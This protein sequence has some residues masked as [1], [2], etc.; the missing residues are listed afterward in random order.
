[1]YDDL[2]KAV[3]DGQITIVVMIDLS[4]AF[5]T[6]DIPIAL[7]ILHDD[8]GIDDVPL[9]WIKSYLTDR[10]MKVIINNDSSRQENL[11]FG[12]PQGSCA[13]L[14]IFTLYIAALKRVVKKYPAQLHGY[15]D[16]HKVALQIQAGN[17]ENETYVLEQL[18][19]CLDNISS[20]MAKYKLKM[21]NAKTEIILYEIPVYQIDRLQRLQNQAARVVMNVYDQPSA[22]LRKSL[23]WLPVK[24]RIMFKVILIV[25]RVIHGTA[26]TYLITLFN[27]VRRKYRLRSAADDTCTQFV[28]PRRRTR[29]A[30][31][32]ISV[33]GPKWWNALPKELKCIASIGNC[34]QKNTEST[35]L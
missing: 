14:V 34:I 32:S 15:A 20:W 19:A 22:D 13:G 11:M 35:S 28:V 2:L 18:S 4:A 5:D 30:D 8:F 23:H 1:M 29:L 27:C 25:F 3:D 7:H 26:P 12:V 9:Q 24:A 17:I 10:T 33:M 16:D 6:I 31:R 21:N